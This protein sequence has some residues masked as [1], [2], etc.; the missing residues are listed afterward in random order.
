MIADT[1]QV[2]DVLMTSIE[3]F[4]FLGLVAIGIFYF[5]TIF[6]SEDQRIT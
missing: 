1:A 3:T 6:L 2:Q 5:V 4:A